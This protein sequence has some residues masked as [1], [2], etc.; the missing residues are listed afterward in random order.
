[1][2]EAMTVQ[3]A[4]SVLDVSEEAS[5]DDTRTAYRN[6]V[7]QWHPDHPELSGESELALSRMREIIEAYR[8]LRAN[9]VEEPNEALSDEPTETR[10]VIGVY[11]GDDH[12]ITAAI[13]SFALAVILFGISMWVVTTVILPRGISSKATAFSFLGLFILWGIL[14]GLLCPVLEQISRAKFEKKRL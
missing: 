11:D 7:K 4:R 5:S 2:S 14:Y 12:E 6:L 10:A 13:A 3:E 9:T 8:V 1:M